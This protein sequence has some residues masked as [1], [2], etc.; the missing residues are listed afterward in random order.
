MGILSL[1]RFSE[2]EN[3]WWGATP[4][5]WNFGS[6]GPH[7]SEISDFE[8]IIAR[9]ASAV[10]PIESSINTNRKSPT[11]FPMSLRWS[12]YVAPKSPEGG[13]ITQNGRFPSKFTLLLKK[14][15]HKVSLCENCQRQSCRA[16]DR[17]IRAKMIGGDVGYGMVRVWV[18]GN[19][20]KVKLFYP[21]VTHGPYLSAFEINSLSKKLAVYFRSVWVAY[22]SSQLASTRWFY[23]FIH[24]CTTTRSN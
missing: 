8:P 3:G 16:Y 23:S 2:K 22:F 18:A 13:S 5:T 4:S 21:L 15:C 19:G 6:T 20:W 7:W 1:C 14:V 9:S 12:S 10:R 11:H 17:A 24:R